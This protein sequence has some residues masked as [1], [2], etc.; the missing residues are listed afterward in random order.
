LQGGLLTTGVGTAFFLLADAIYAGMSNDP[1]VRAVGALA[2][3]WLAFVQ[4]FL[5]AGIIYIGAL[6]GAG[7]EV[8]G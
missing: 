6:R 3:R 7:G 1:Q 2:F 4:P 8:H 5:A